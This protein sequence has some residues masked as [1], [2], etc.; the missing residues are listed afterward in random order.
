MFGAATLLGAFFGSRTFF[1]YYRYADNRMTWGR[2]LAPALTSWYLWALLVPLIFLLARRFPVEKGQR[3]T[4][5]LIHM[6]GGVVFSILYSALDAG[7]GQFLPWMTNRQFS[8]LASLADFHSNLLV[9]AAIVAAVH[10]VTSYQRNRERELV[11]S[12][13]EARLAEARLQV[14]RMQLH[15][16]FLFNTLHAISTLMHRDVDSAE[17]ML[18]RLSDL[19]RVAL[20]SEGA[21]QVPLKDELELLERYLDIERIRFG[22]RLSVTVDTDP[23]ALDALV[24][25]LILQPLVENAIRHG[26]APRAG[27]GW[28]GVRSELEDKWLRI[29][30]EDDGPGLDNSRAADGSGQGGVGLSNSQARLQ[31]LYGEAHEFQMGTSETGG[32]RILIRIP[33]Q[34]AA[35]REAAGE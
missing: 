29:T 31:H 12:R 15:P 25:H 17:R 13:L 18:V 8:T 35:T 33:Y 6:L 16:H 10:L 9:Y 14:L 20:E 7:I 19:L 28:I 11:A 34:E 5:L 24:P 4:S 1:T 3:L 21:Q 30:I 26:I 2:A 23:D 27:P 22:S 32:L